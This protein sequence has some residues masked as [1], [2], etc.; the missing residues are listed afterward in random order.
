MS[1]F[2][3]TFSKVI[4]LI[5]SHYSVSDNTDYLNKKK[6]PTFSNKN[7]RLTSSLLIN[8]IMEN[9]YESSYNYST[10]LLYPKF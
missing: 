2:L 7:V 4:W 10:Y 6:K 5:L 1:Y 8:S 3:E 9:Q